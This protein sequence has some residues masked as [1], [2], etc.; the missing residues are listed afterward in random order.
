M[1]QRAY[2]WQFWR[3]TPSE[4]RALTVAEHEA[5]VGVMED[6]ARENKKAAQRARARR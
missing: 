6:V 2:F 5:M 3:I 1:R 4:Y